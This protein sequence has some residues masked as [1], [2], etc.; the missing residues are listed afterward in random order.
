M[1]LILD[2]EIFH[3]INKK[4]VELLLALDVCHGISRGVLGIGIKFQGQPSVWVVLKKK[5]V[6]Q[7][8][9]EPIFFLEPFIS[10]PSVVAF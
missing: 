10:V 8:N 9:H 1:L 6:D 7:Q 3:W 4:K 2:V 5:A